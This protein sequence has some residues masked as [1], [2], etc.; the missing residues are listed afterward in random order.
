MMQYDV[1]LSVSERGTGV[2]ITRRDLVIG[3]F[4]V[5]TP[6]GWRDY[7]PFDKLAFVVAAEPDQVGF[8][9]ATIDVKGV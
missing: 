8:F 5:L 1:Y 4:E 2:A 9:T 3:T 7:K 6:D